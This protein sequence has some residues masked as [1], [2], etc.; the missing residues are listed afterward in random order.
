MPKS[1]ENWR[2][3]VEMFGFPFCPDF[4]SALW[5]IKL[6]RY[7]EK[8]REPL[9]QKRK[10]QNGERG[11]ERSHESRAGSPVLKAGGGIGAVALGE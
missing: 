6:K 10:P 11:V 9:S 8:G 2:G 5:A 3:M 7:L 4:H 1:D